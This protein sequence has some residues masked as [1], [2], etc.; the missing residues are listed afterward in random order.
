MSDISEG[1][2]IVAAAGFTAIITA[3]QLHATAEDRRAERREQRSDQQRADAALV[4]GDIEAARARLLMEL[5]VKEKRDAVCRDQLDRQRENICLWDQ[6]GRQ[7]PIPEFKVSSP[8]PS[9]KFRALE[10][11]PLAVKSLPPDVIR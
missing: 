8:Y 4:L 1:L 5:A 10:A 11:D 7:G 2:A 3:Y 6:G 9:L